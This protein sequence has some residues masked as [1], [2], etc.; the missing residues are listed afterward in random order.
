MPN[1]FDEIYWLDDLCAFADKLPEHQ[2][3]YVYSFMLESMMGKY[4]TL[5]II[6]EGWTQTEFLKYYA[7][8][9]RWNRVFT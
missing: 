6:P 1:K 3:E 4:T 2:R 7:A 9:C 5:E 8:H